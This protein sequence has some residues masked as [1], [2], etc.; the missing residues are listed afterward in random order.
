MRIFMENEKTGSTHPTNRNGISPLAI[1]LL[2]LVIVLSLFIRI[3]YQQVMEIDSPIRSDALDF[4]TYGYNIVSYEI[5]SKDSSSDRM[6]DSYR[7]PGYPFVIALSF[8]I[9]GK[10]GFYPLILYFQ[11]AISTLMVFFT[12]LMGKRFLSLWSAL[13][14]T[15]LVALSPHLISMTSYLLTETLFGFLLLSALLCLDHSIKTHKTTPILCA[16]ILFGYAYLVNETTLFLPY[17]LILTFYI[18]NRTEFRLRSSFFIKLL[19]F[20]LV[21][22][23]FPFSWIIRNH[24]SIPDGSDTGKNRA[25]VT[26]TH[27]SYPGFI[28]KSERYRYI[29]YLEDPTYPEFKKSL[30]NFITIFSERF[31][32]RPIRY[33]Q[34]YFFEKPYCLWSWDILNGE[35]DIYV[36]PHEASLYN[37]SELAY[38]SKK[39]MKLFHPLIVLIATLS[40]PIC[41]FKFQNRT[42]SSVATSV[43]L[44]LTT[45]LYFTVLYSVFAPWPRY[46]IPLRP[47]LY[48]LF[49]WGANILMRFLYI[50]LRRRP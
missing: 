8:L 49:L 1:L 27:G 23:M 50:K 44:I 39:I 48:L 35:G 32:K 17:L 13:I 19:L 42:Q 41:I 14:A 2:L 28:Y 11:T 16:A 4:V 45:V 26:L 33:L 31:K 25:I 12:F 10:K 43:I 3:R 30:T 22:T 29:P 18:M 5:Y 37:L 21:F 15:L 47:E 6:P 46:S 36:Y 9:G 38:Y 34:W 24:I 20:L 40:I 7:S